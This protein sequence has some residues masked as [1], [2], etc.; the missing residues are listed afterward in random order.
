MGYKSGVNML[1]VDFEPNVKRAVILHQ[2]K[3][4]VS[5]S[6]IYVR[7]LLCLP[8][9]LRH[10]SRWMQLD[11]L[12]PTNNPSVARSILTKPECGTWVVHGQLLHPVNAVGVNWRPLGRIPCQNEALVPLAFKTYPK[13]RVV[14]I[15]FCPVVVLLNYL[16]S[17]WMSQVYTL[18]F[19][20]EI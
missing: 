19:E 6:P 8:E 18:L 12:A 4:A 16:P 14:M 13:K 2:S 17:K 11:L 5:K 15:V 10:F 9:V 1:F 3:T 20:Q 7:L